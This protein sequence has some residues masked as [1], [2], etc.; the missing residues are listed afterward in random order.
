[1]KGVAK[2]KYPLVLSDHQGGLHHR[3]I[4]ERGRNIDFTL[5]ANKQI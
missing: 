1:M 5:V 2:G 3:S 4:L